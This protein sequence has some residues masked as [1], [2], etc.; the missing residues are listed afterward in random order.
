LFPDSFAISP[1][2]RQLAFTAVDKDGQQKLWV[3]ALGTTTARVL[4]GTEQAAEPFWSPDSHEI[5]FFTDTQL[6]RINIAGGGPLTA[7][8]TSHRR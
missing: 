2:G 8:G 4:A 5:A 1:D 7:C 3:R 6:K